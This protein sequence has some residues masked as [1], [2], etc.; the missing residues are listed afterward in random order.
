MSHK[1]DKFLAWTKWPFTIL[2]L[3]F[4]FALVKTLLSGTWILSQLLDNFLFWAGI[5]GCF[6]AWTYIFKKP[7]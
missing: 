1:I 6:L 2:A 5:G 3:V 7:V 4:G